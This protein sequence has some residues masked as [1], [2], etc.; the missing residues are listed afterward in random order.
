MPWQQLVADVGFEIQDG[1]PA[2]REIVITVPRQSGKTSLMLA[3]EVHRAIAWGDLQTIAYTAQTGFDARQKL[4]NDQVP[5]LQASEI[6]PAIRK[7]YLANGKESVI[8]RNG[9][10]IQV[11]PS[12]PTAGHGKTIALGVI[13]EAFADEEGIREASLLP[14]MATRADAQMIV[15]S[16]AGT[17][18]ALYLRRK[19]EMG[20][21]STEVANDAGIAY[22]EWSADP[23]D[24][25]FDP[26]TWAACMP[27]LGHTIREDAIRHAIGSMSLA[28]FRRAYLNTWTISDDRLIPEKVW[29]S[30]TSTATTPTGKLAF[31]VDVALDR[32]R[33]S[34]AV[35]DADG[36]VE[37]I[38]AQSGVSWVLNRAHQ[39]ARRWNAPIV[40]DGYSPAGGLIEPL[41]NLGVEVVSY[42]LPDVVAACNLLYDAILEKAVKVKTDDRLDR[43]VAAVRKKAVGNSWLWARN[44]IDA[45]LTPLYAATVAWHF[46]KHRNTDHKPRSRVF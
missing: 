33:A 43:A 45:D 29:R 2:Y 12:T 31:G 18:S 22:F 42:R 37:I 10:R 5:V 15:V 17:D 9:S 23:D 27:A 8:F 14:A 40:I 20:R 4:I 32:S 13:D 36:H 35:A 16:T 28:D 38:E 3:W 1:L 24:D 44:V 11:L 46:A 26:E 39:L 6:R 30:C 19:V 21:A 25:P 7:I 34:I 41:A